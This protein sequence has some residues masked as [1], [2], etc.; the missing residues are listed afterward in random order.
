MGWDIN[1]VVLVGRVCNELELKNA[2]DT[3]VVN[4]NLAVGGKT[5]DKSDFFHVSVW[6]KSAENCA[7][8]L[9]KGKQIIVTGHLEQK[10]YALKDGQNREK[11]VINAERVQ[12]IGGYGKS[13]GNNST[14]EFIEENF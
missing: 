4:I 14:K 9:S 3:S 1:H 8:F 2:G 12:F 13:E 5:K 11:T 6:G 7:K 10:T